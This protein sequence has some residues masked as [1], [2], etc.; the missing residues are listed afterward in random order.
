ML[1]EDDLAEIVYD[2]LKSSDSRTGNLRAAMNEPPA[3]KGKWGFHAREPYNRPYTSLPVRRIFLSEYDIK[4]RLA[5]GQKQLRV[6][7]GAI[8]SPLAEEWLTE[9]GIRVEF[10]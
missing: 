1:S 8:I 5:P 3:R 6:P 10:E 2:A 7:R 4:Q 9:K